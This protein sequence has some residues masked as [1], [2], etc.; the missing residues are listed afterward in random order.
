MKPIWNALLDFIG[1][2][3]GYLISLHKPVACLLI[4]HDWRDG[5]KFCLR[6]GRYK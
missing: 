6:C 1:A 5:Y 3:W 4:G 2:V